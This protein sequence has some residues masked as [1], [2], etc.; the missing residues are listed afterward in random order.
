MQTTDTK[1]WSYVPFSHSQKYD[2]ADRLYARKIE[3][4]ENELGL[5]HPKVADS[6]KDRA[7]CL[8]TQ[9]G[10]FCSYRN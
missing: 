3:I 4:L 6:L 8:T 5:D 1:K 7:T 9:V 10:Q 2:E